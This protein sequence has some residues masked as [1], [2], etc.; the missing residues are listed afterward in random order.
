MEHLLIS[1]SSVRAG[2]VS[3]VLGCDSFR[4]KASDLS[5]YA[6]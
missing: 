4:N 2:K 1:Q 3:A 6:D 5:H